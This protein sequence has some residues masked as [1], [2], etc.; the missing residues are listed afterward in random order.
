MLKFVIPVIF[1][2]ILC[3]G[4]N[5]KQDFEIK[6][7]KKIDYF[8]F[9]SDYVELKK[10][11]GFSYINKNHYRVQYLDENLMEIE[12][13]ISLRG[14]GEDLHFK[15]S[16]KTS[17]KDQGKI[18]DEK[19]GILKEKKCF[20][21]GSSNV[22]LYWDDCRDE[23]EKEGKEIYEGLKTILY[24][25]S[26]NGSF[27][28]KEE[29]EK[30]I[31]YSFNFEKRNEEKSKEE[32]EKLYNNKKFLNE[33]LKNVYEP[34]NI[35]GNIIVSKELKLPLKTE[36]SGEFII[37]KDGREGNLFLDFYGELTPLGA[38]PEIAIP[39]KFRSSR[40]NS[41]KKMIDYILK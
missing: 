26:Q 16:K 2:F 31:T 12:E 35:R 14:G 41:I 19:E 28:E 5:K 1:L 22:F 37:K 13:E 38:K 29:D 39:K 24:I 36:I 15:I 23:P 20:I 34:Q 25:L 30:T 3:R 10:L 11:N 32:I 21:R 17:L 4:E 7:E 18:I 9:H 6:R 8:P 33:W 40:R 27:S